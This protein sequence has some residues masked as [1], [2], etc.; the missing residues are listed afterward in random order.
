M[1]VGLGLLGVGVGLVGFVATY[2]LA[3]ASSPPGEHEDWEPARRRAWMISATILAATLV[4]WAVSMRSRAPFS[5]GQTLGLGFLIGGI[6]G[7]AMCMLALRFAVLDARGTLRTRCLT[8]NS[9]SFWA[10][11]AVSLT[12]LLFRGYPQNALMGFGMGAAMAAVLGLLLDRRL[13]LHIQ[14]W[15]AF[16]I[17]I[18]A[19]TVLAVLHFDRTQLRVWWSL[20]LLL[21]TTVCAAGYLGSEL[22]CSARWRERTGAGYLISALVSAV[23]VIGLSAIYAWRLV[24]E[25]QLLEVMVVGVVVAALV[26]WVAAS[27]A[28]SRE[29]F[30]GQ[31][32]GIAIVLLIAAFAVVAFKL[33]AGL[34]LALGLL[35][36]WTLVLPSLRFVGQSRE[37]GGADLE[38]L[39]RALCGAVI[40]GLVIVLFRLFIQQYREELG[41]TDLRIHYTYIGALLG[42]VIPF[43]LASRL[44]R[45]GLSNGGCDRCG[46]ADG[47][48]I[49]LVAAVSPVVLFLVWQI[50]AV[51]GLEF[52]LSAAAA[53]AVMRSVAAYDGTQGQGSALYREG[54]LILGAQLVAI[55]FTGALTGLELTRTSR[56]WALAIA[57]TLAAVW[58]IV[59]GVVAARRAR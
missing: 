19:A 53:Y 18:A 40:F 31:D 52:G 45:A 57:V 34:G 8:V 2:L 7:A 20:P 26:A 36:V 21:A 46:I 38:A 10:L 30:V 11:F 12:Y 4:F 54:V 51:L 25:W 33:W 41:T 6:A 58:L 9:T 50:K 59:A 35:G 32:A 44:Q 14:T 22:S 43:F 49:G 23:L 56:I 27:A 29:T 24:A 1:D 13:A 55:Q 28:K 5:P 48:A 37:E 47:V 15:A 42:L 3:S 17:T 39:P 16:S